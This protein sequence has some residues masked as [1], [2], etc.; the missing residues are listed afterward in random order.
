ME[1]ADIFFN[2]LLILKCHTPPPEASGTIKEV[3]IPTGKSMRY[4]A[5]IIVLAGAAQGDAQPREDWTAYE[6][7]LREHG[8]ATSGPGLL[9]T[10]RER[11][12]SREKIA[13][14]AEQVK[15]LA[16]PKYAERTKAAAALVKEGQAA[17]PFLL[18]LINDPQ[19]DA[20]AA[21]RAELCLRRI[22][23]GPEVTIAI[24]TAQLIGR[25]RPDGAA[26]VLLQ[27]VPFVTDPDAMEAVQ[28]ALN[29]VASKA[30]KPEPAFV[31][32]LK[33]AAPPVRAAAAE[34]LVRGGGMTSKALVEPLLRDPS[35]HVRMQVA[36]VLAE[37]KEKTAVPVLI[38]LLGDLRGDQKNQVEDFLLPWP[39][40][41][42]PR[43]LTRPRQ[44]KSNAGGACGGKTTRPD[45][46]SAASNTLSPLAPRWLRCYCQD[47][48]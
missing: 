35:S 32:A 29:A 48:N 25:D 36:L 23:D 39:V 21:R 34:A 17:K 47:R 6:R 9:T 15:R 13:S 40:T 41:R 7:T 1:A 4:V 18:Q 31:A 33:D 45:W 14:L 2:R 12:P 5:L 20:E 43:S 28:S 16:A 19:A 8:L 42:R 3:F 27:Y 37:A 24:A 46:I 22:E 10:L 30:G 11:T 38:D 26:R 44:A